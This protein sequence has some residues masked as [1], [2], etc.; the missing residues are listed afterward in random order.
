V[1]RTISAK[2]G[3]HIISALPKT[4]MLETIVAI[5]VSE[6]SDVLETAA[7]LLPVLLASPENR[8]AFMDKL[9]GPLVLARLVGTAMQVSDMM[10]EA[11]LGTLPLLGMVQ[12]ESSNNLQF[13]SGRS[14]RIQCSQHLI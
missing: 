7:L 1:V 12:T 11:A 13:A 3:S 14:A 5:L 8:S 9:N 4:N 2:P 10:Q 6:S